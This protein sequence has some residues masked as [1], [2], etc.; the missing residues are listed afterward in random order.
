MSYT[1]LL[2]ACPRV[3]LSILLRTTLTFFFFAASQRAEE[4]CYK[5]QEAP[6]RLTTN[7]G[8]QISVACNNCRQRKSKVS[9][10]PQM[11]CACSFATSANIYFLYQYIYADP[12]EVQRRT[13]NLQDMSRPQGAVRIHLGTGHLTYCLAQTKVWCVNEEHNPISK[14]KFRLRTC[15]S[16]LTNHTDLKLDHE[17]M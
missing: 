4:E 10:P 2:K 6:V 17:S 16:A 14:S 15:L 13:P 8:E 1:S 9:V 3:S 12:K 5:I 11:R 7:A